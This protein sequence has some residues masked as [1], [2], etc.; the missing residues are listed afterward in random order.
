MTRTR[1]SSALRTRV[2]ECLVKIGAGSFK[3]SDVASLFTLLRQEAPRGSWTREIRD[4]IN[5]PVRERG[6]L[7]EHCKDT[8]L[9][10]ASDGAVRLNIQAV[11]VDVLVENLN[12]IVESIG[13]APIRSE[14][15]PAVGAVIIDMLQESELDYTAVQ[16]G[17]KV[18][19]H[20]I[21]PRDD[22]HAG[23]IRL[24]AFIPKVRGMTGYAFP[25]VMMENVFD[26]P[27]YLP[28]LDQLDWPMLKIE[29]QVGVPR[30]FQLSEPF[31]WDISDES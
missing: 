10:I 6:K 17:L 11:H 19:L 8:V 16:D 18:T 31:I 13:C 1:R 22:T 9:K 23:D 24:T 26:L 3:D 14:R 7:W 4:H 12:T 29:F 2:T 27:R 21:I 28:S 20:A 25:V 5:H 30:C 15:A